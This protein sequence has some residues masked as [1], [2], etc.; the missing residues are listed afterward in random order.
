MDSTAV[1]AI[2]ENTTAV[3][4]LTGT[5]WTFAGFIGFMVCGVLAIRYTLK[6]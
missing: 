2:T 3:M 6:G 4:T 5:L 1:Q